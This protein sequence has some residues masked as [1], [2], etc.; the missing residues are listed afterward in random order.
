MDIRHNPSATKQ[1]DPETQS[2]KKVI[3]L[4]LSSL[5]IERWVHDR[6]YMQAE[7]D[8][9]GILLNVTDANDDPELQIS[10]AEN[11]ILQGVDILIVVANDGTS[12][13]KIVE[14]AH[15]KGVKVIAYDR[16]ILDSDLDYYISFDSVEVG[17]KQAEGVLAVSGDKQN[18]AYIGG[19]PTDHNA[20]LLEMGSKEVLQPKLDSGEITLVLDELITDWKQEEAYRVVKEFLAGGGELDAVIAANDGNATGVIQALSEYGL[21]GTVPVSGQ[22]AE[23][24]ACRRIVEGTQTMTVYKPLQSLAI[25]AIDLA[26]RI[27]NGEEIDVSETIYNGK[28][29]VPAF[30]I[31]TVSVT[32][33]NM[34]NTIVKD[35]FHTYEEIY[36]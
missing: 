6:D 28:I 8:K 19:S 14:L 17:K 5:R 33:E 18:F 4:S 13:G 2:E 7:A 12:A 31:G 23:L 9:R 20:I 25:G 22:D 21:A 16:L 35:G 10:Q 34:V 29:D 30:Y 24:S 36:K 15:A 11:L 27:I 26:D 1:E 3:G 32:K